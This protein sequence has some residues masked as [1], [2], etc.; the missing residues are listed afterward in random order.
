MENKLDIYKFDMGIINLNKKEIP[1]LHLFNNVI[2][3]LRTGI[4][5]NGAT[6][7]TEINTTTVKKVVCDEKRIEQVLSN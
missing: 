2:N 1:I 5:E 3:D 7:I 4:E 6:I